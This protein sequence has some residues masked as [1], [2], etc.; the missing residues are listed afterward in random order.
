MDLTFCFTGFFFLLVFM[1]IF[2]ACLFVC[3]VCVWYPQRSEQG[4]AFFVSGITGCDLVVGCFFVF[5]LF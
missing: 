1:S 5:V 4:I 3:T 2:P